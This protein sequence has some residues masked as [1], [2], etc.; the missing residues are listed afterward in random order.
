MQTERLLALANWL[1][2]GAKHSLRIGKRDVVFDMSVGIR[3]MAEVGQDFDPNA[4]GTACC[5]AGAAVEFF[6]PKEAASLLGNV[7]E[8]A[9]G[10]AAIYVDDYGDSLEDPTREFI[11]DWN[12]TLDAP[13]MGVEQGVE[14]GVFDTA[15][16]LLGLSDMQASML[17]LPSE[18]TGDYSPPEHAE[19]ADYTDPLWAARAIRRGVE[20]GDFNWHA[21]ERHA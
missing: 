6:A 15:R 16:D 1:E 18:A 13:F 12:G 2:G 10:V 4:C 3:V 21:V 11:N 8:E 5:V 19:L 17:F 20:T 9:L 7:R 14:Q